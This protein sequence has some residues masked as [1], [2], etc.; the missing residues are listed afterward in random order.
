MYWFSVQS[1]NDPMNRETINRSSVTLVL[2]LDVTT[3]RNYFGL[4]ARSHRDMTNSP[5]KLHVTAYRQRIG[6]E[7]GLEPTTH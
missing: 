6:S 5:L 2:P 7:N 3:P 4:I 1:T